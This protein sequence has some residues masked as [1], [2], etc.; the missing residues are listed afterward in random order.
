MWQPNTK[1]SMWYG[2]QCGQLEFRSILQH[3]KKSYQRAV[4]I[5][6]IM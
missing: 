5:A 1:S 3:T 6:D 4:N 2:I